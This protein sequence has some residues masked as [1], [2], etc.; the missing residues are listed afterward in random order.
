M[1]HLSEISH[2]RLLEILSYEPIVGIFRW[3]EK[4][5]PCSHVGAIAGSPQRGGHIQIG[6]DGEKYKA[7]RLAWFYVYGVWPPEDIDHINCI[8]G[9]NRLCNLRLASRAQNLRN[10]GV[11]RNNTSGFKGVTFH[12]PTKKWRARILHN[13]VRHNLGLFDTPELA[14][15]AYCAASERLHGEFARAA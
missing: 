14:H 10:C 7:H 9:D 11:R 3:R 5:G 15:A 8:R 6:I 12:R 13:G 4:T 1:K 2:S